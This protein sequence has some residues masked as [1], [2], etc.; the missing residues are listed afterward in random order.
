[1]NTKLAVKKTSDTN[2]IPVMYQIIDMAPAGTLGD[3]NCVI[4][5]ERVGW[6]TEDNY[7][8]W[9]ETRNVV[10]MQGTLG[11]F[12]VATLDTLQVYHSRTPSLDM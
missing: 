10:G 9:K 4:M 8:A 12:E 11:D 1:M 6:D 7:D 5:V 2:F 3:T